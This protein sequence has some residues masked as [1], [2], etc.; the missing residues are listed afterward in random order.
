LILLPDA[1]R[2]NG[3]RRP[4]LSEVRLWLCRSGGH[5]DE[6]AHGGGRIGYSERRD[7]MHR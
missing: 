4:Q 6:Y 1:L 7:V 2:A 5:H 3:T